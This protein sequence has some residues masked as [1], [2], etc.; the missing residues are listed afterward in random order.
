MWSLPIRPP[1][2]TA[3]STPERP[4]DSLKAEN[5]SLIISTDVNPSPGL[6]RVSFF[7]SIRVLASDSTTSSS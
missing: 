4:L 7:L 1:P 2:K 5:D 6:S 3:G